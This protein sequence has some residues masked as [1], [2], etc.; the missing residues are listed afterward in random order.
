M[1]KVNHFF[2][3]SQACKATMWIPRRTCFV[4][5]TYRSNGTG[6]LF[7]INMTGTPLRP[8]LEPNAD[9]FI[10]VRSA[11]IPLTYNSVNSTNNVLNLTEL[12]GE[13]F[14]DFLV[15]IPP[16]QYDL[17]AMQTTLSQVMSQ[18]SSAS[19]LG[20]TYDAV[21]STTTGSVTFSLVDEMTTTTVNII[22]SN[23]TAIS[24]LG[25][26]STGTATWTNSTSYTG[27]GI[28]SISGPRYI[29]IRS[30]SFIQDNYEVAINGPSNIL[31]TFPIT[32]P[33]F[34]MQI[35]NPAMPITLSKISCTIDTMTFNITD[36][37]G[38]NLDL[39][40]QPVQFLLALYVLP[41]NAL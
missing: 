17:L 12:Q 11:A 29:C 25:L 20:L 9:T 6:S 38:I 5:S 26:P 19:G 7:T 10:A 3:A 1:S 27:S 16:G 15:I 8:A 31:E 28:V 41:K 18:A 32:A 30:Q 37:N 22:L 24:I 39:R 4:N 14:F 2:V 33:Q 21:I 36:E 13:S 35:F 23:S 34:S 40:G